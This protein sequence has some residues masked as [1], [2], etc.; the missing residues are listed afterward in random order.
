[1]SGGARAI[2]YALCGYLAML[3]EGALAFVLPTN[4]AFV[5]V[6]ELALSVVTYLGLAGRGGAPALV[7]SA[8]TIGYLRDLLCGAPRGV[9]ALAFAICALVARAMHGRVF[10]DRWGQLSA[11]AVAIT[12][13]HA[14]LVVLLGASD[15]P[16]LASLRVLPGL[17]VAA[18]V[19]GPASLRALRR[20]DLRLVPDDRSLRMEGE[21]GGAWR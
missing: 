3:V 15:A 8:L 16:L 12:T 17:L 6:P 4:R 18:L 1:V 10:L 9:E 13:F 5:A 14:L 21:L 11:V 7:A 2:I 19:V 20:L